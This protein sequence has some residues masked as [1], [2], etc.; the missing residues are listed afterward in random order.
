MFCFQ[1]E[2]T[3][4]GE[5][6]TRVGVCGKSAEVSDWQ[7]EV[8]LALVELALAVEGQ[9]RR[10]ESDRLMLEALFLTITN[11]N[12]DPEDCEAMVRRLREETARYGD[13]TAPEG[14]VLEQAGDVFAGDT[15]QVSL[16]T[17]LLLGL[18]G[19]A[20]YAEH[21][22]V[23]GYRDEAM[24][25][26][27]WRYLRA[28]AVEHDVP[29]WLELL[30]DFG[31][32][33]YRCMELLDEANTGRYGVPE[34]TEV[35]MTIQPGPFIVVS[36]HDLGDLDQLLEQ[37]AGRGVDIYTH[38]EMLPC[39]GYPELKRHPHLRGHFG[40]AWQNQQREFDGVPGAFL[41]TTN[42]LMPPRP[43][44]ADR[45][46][47]TSVVGFP[48]LVHIEADAEGRKDFG[49]VIE[50]AI[51]LGGWDEPHVMK[52]IN[53]G[54]TLHTGFG[55]GTVLSLAPQIIE[56]V[57]GGEISHF[58][59]IGGCDGAR[60]G[61]NY[62]TELAESTPEDSIILTVA[63]GK[64]RFNDIDFGTVGAFPR[65]L[66]M[67]QCNDS[68]SA[69]RV[70][71]ALAEAFECTVND[72]PLSII[73]S[74][75]E[76]KAVCVLLTLLALGVRDIKLGPS[77]PAFVSPDVLNVLVE[78]FGLAPITTPAEDLAR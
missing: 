58:Y 57:K 75:Y 11:V 14:L 61:R 23:L 46:F 17:L 69:I 45:V 66:D 32:S 41:F 54:S 74:W 78:Q 34:P 55:H 36:G 24:F 31:M 67:G 53:G 63:C 44:Y 43:S 59:L 5:A 19:M 22:Y 1:C 28:L 25:E 13:W 7:D 2:Q 77:L 73:L 30:H 49:P 21:A 15:N 35:S 51:A 37:T 27:M 4:R 71:L 39:H 47:T 40:T 16:R 60:P 33:N 76:Q 48:E 72:L 29:T 56:A 38:G 62:Y 10:P 50:R 70:A 9:E 52:G 3:A 65:L 6:C 18:R 8:T 64:F 68:Y 42:C 12:F 20:A 26:D